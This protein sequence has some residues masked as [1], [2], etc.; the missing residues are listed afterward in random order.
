MNLY[1]GILLVLLTAYWILATII[2]STALLAEWEAEDGK[3]KM[4]H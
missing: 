1:E 2:R 4:S 3:E